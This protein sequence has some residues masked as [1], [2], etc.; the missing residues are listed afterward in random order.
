MAI[1]GHILFMRLD[2]DICA[3]A[4]DEIIL[5]DLSEYQ[6][7]YILTLWVQSIYLQRIK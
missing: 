7:I 1:K 3:N 5:L 4:Y 6:S 2:L